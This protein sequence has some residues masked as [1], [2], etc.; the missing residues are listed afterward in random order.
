MTTP[1]RPDV[2]KPQLP[3]RL[4]QHT[5]FDGWTLEFDTLN[6]IKKAGDKYGGASLEVAE[7]IAIETEAVLQEQLATYAR[8]LESEIEK[9]KRVTES[10]VDKLCIRDGELECAEADKKEILE[11]ITR[12]FNKLS[13]YL[14]DNK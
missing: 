7:A 9:W 13:N 6:R 2:V 3:R 1:T 4:P 14:E 10:L 8:Q 5:A 12:L 11:S